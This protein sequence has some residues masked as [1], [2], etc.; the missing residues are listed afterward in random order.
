MS[1]WNEQLYIGV[2]A[3]GPLS[4]V[5]FYALIAIGTWMLLNLFIAILIQGF[6]EQ[7]AIK[8]R[9]N[10]KHLQLTM[11]HY[12]SHESKDEQEVATRIEELFEVFD[13]DE[14]GDIDIYELSEGLLKLKIALRPKELQ[15]VMRKYDTTSTGTIEFDEF[16]QMMLEMKREKEKVG[17]HIATDFAAPCLEEAGTTLRKPGKHHKGKGKAMPFIKRD[18]DEKVP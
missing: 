4:G 14:S 16:V 1:N 7:K 12:M 5:F 6:A 8:Y 18:A 9:Q 10:M 3:Q 17:P 11:V 13:E 15:D 2:K